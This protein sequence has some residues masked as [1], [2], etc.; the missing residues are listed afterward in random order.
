[1]NALAVFDDGSGPAL[2]AAGAFNNA[3]GIPAHHLARWR[4]GA[5]SAVGSGLDGDARAMAVFGPPGSAKLFVGGA[6]T[7][8][9]GNASPHIA[10]WGPAW[11]ANCDHSTT[12]PLLTI[13]DFACF[14][15]RFA[16][17]D[18]YAN[19]DGSATPPILTVADF[20]CFL[21]AFAAGCS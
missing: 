18:P 1:V 14:L 9:G 21:N 19:C 2:Y 7:T 12:P 3:A 16:A 11:S 13:A 5:W 15:N 17:G 6:F 10:A 8:A 20:G 4:N